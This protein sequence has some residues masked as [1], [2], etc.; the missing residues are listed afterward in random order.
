MKT[1]LSEWEEFYNKNQE[2]LTDTPSKI[3]YWRSMLEKVITFIETNHRRPRAVDR[4]REA[5]SD[6]DI[7]ANWL[8]KYTRT[9][10]TNST[11]LDKLEIKPAWQNFKKKYSKFL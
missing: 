7:L 1:Y 10:Q 9:Q 11:W 4:T 5:S 2:Y 3:K 6:E 8:C